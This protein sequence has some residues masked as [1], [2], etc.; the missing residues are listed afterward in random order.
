M[1]LGAGI[2]LMLL[3]LMP[4]S[5]R[6]GTP[7]GIVSKRSWFFSGELLNSI[8]CYGLIS[9]CKLL[10]VLFLYEAIDAAELV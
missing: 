4:A 9:E 3:P 1:C 5:S 8:S 6:L 10:I 7:L 2:S